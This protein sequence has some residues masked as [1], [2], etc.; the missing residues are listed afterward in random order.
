MT[1][2]ARTLSR[3]TSSRAVS[4]RSSTCFSLGDSDSD[5]SRAGHGGLVGELQYSTALF[6]AA[7]VERMAGH[8]VTCWDAVCSTPRDRW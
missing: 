7:T 4:R 8:I 5:G 3:P 1:S 6:D 2:S